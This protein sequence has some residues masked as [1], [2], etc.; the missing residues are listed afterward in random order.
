M[1]CIEAF[2]SV[3]IQPFFVI[4]LFQVKMSKNDHTQGHLWVFFALILLYTYSVISAILI[5]KILHS[6]KK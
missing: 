5:K 3:F 1:G 6:V 2:N 4:N